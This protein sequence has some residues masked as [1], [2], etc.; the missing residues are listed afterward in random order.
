MTLLHALGKKKPANGMAAA[1][2][3]FE[4]EHVGT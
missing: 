1:F 4:A 2:D 3:N